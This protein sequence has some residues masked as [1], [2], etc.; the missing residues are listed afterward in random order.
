MREGVRESGT[1]LINSI[2]TYVLYCMIYY[3][4]NESQ[5]SLL[6]ITSQEK[7]CGGKL[8]NDIV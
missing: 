6:D 4:T 8:Y 7:I 5:H 3:A 2:Y 1:D